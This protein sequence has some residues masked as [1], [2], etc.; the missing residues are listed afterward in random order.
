MCLAHPVYR[1]F[2]LQFPFYD[3]TVQVMYEKIMNDPLECPPTMPAE[4]SMLLT[5][6]LD[7][8]P[9]TR[10][11]DPN[12]IKRESFFSGIDWERLFKKQVKPPYVPS[13]TSTSDTSQ[14][15]PE[16]TSEIPEDQVAEPA[17]RGSND[18]ENFTFVAEG[19]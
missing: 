1:C 11:T 8:N 10:M 12:Q 5:S 14:I 7:K 9:V 19:K 13:V 3:E 16:F 4:A 2:V 6:L 17:T 15:D 18:F